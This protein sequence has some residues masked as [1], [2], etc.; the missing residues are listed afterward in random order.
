M[1]TIQWIMLGA[2][3]GAVGLSILKLYVFFPN[4]PLLDDDT[5]PQ[6]VEKL[7][8]IMVECD[9]LDPYLNDENL[10]QKMVEHPDFDSAFF[11]RF[12]LNRLRHLI[13]DYRLKDPI[14]RR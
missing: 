2:F 13:N 8:R 1:D 12:N 11:W 7:Q 9:R 10:F 4:K 5:T 6:A 3:I 14:F